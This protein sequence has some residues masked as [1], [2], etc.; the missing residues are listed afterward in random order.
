MCV[1]ISDLVEG[2][3]STARQFTKFAERF[4]EISNEHYT[5][6]EI[7]SWTLVQQQS[8]YQFEHM[9][10]CSLDQRWSKF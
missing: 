7:L 2:G 3:W 8:A 6:P 10:T 9:K 4:L 1:F 5:V